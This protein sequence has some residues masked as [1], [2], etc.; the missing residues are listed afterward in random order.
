MN[1]P[2]KPE[3]SQVTGLL[4]AILGVL[5]ETELAISM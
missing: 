5:E 2:R 4:Q 3:L 1:G